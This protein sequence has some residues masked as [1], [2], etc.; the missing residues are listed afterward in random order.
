MLHLG[1]ESAARYV[2]CKG[3]RLKSSQRLQVSKSED[4]H[5]CFVTGETKEMLIQTVSQT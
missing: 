4:T 1:E 3:W 2:A 5:V